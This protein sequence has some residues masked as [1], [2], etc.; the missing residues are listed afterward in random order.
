MK[1][2]IMWIL[3]KIWWDGSSIEGDH[4]SYD[5]IKIAYNSILNQTLN[6]WEWVIMDDTGD[7]EHFIF[8]KNILS[9]DPRVRLYK[10]VENSGNIGN[11]K[12]EAVALCRGKYVLEMDHAD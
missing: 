10:R 9:V 3:W 5:Y 6:D 7:E 2:V 1:L 4:K 12:N 8:L 11:V